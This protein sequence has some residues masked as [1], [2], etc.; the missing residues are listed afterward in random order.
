MNMLTVVGNLTRDAATRQAGE[1]TVT[2]F[3]IAENKKVKG[4]KV[5]MYYD[6]SMWGDRGANIAQYLTIGGQVTVIGE[7]MPIREKEGKFYIDIRVQDVS[8]P[9]KPKADHYSADGNGAENW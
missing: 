6:C 1:S 2:S 7:L 9:A 5:T 4:E 3:S 8:L